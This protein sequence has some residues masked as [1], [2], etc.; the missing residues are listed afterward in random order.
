MRKT[1]HLD[2]GHEIDLYWDDLGK[3]YNLTLIE[4]WHD[5][6]KLGVL[7][8]DES[9]EYKTPHYSEWFN[10]KKDEDKAA[11][12]YTELYPD[13]A[14]SDRK[15]LFEKGLAREVD[16][17]AVATRAREVAKAAAQRGKGPFF[18]IDA[19]GRIVA[20]GVSTR[21]AMGQA[22][23]CGWR[24]WYSPDRADERTLAIVPL[25]RVRVKF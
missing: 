17:E 8:L 11:A 4:V 15:T 18:A 3:G 20:W 13:L 12:R 25:E 23:Y 14:R 21:S 5:K 22:G 2:S 6:T 24:G 1:I 10:T 9:G 19:E 16:L 7:V